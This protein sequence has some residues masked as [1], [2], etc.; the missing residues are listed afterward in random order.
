MAMLSRNLK[1]GIMRKKVKL[2]SFGVF[3]FFCFTTKAKCVSY[4][5]IK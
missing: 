5:F 3:G 1:V 4:L 2:M